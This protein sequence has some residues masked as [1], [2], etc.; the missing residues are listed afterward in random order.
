MLWPGSIV[1]AG[2]E[3][4]TEGLAV[5]TVTA[6]VEVALS[7]GDAGLVVPASVALTQ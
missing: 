2:G 6:S 4:E 7:L 1:G 3:T 5:S